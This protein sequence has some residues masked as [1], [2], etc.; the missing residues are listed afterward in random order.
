MATPRMKRRRRRRRAHGRRRSGH[1]SAQEGK[2]SASRR[3]QR[4]EVK[5]KPEDGGYGSPVNRRRL[6]ILRRAIGQPGGVEWSS[7]RGEKLRG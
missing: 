5:E 1:Y 7:E 2:R 4:R 3:A 6:K